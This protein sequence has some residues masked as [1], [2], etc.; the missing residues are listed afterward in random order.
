MT[1]AIFDAVFQITLVVLAWRILRARDL[2]SAVLLLCAFGLLVAL[3]WVRLN[4]PDVALAEAALGS[5]VLGALMLGAIRRLDSS[6]DL[7]EEDAA[8]VGARQR[9]KSVAAGAG[10]AGIGIML[11]VAVVD[12]AG[13]SDGLTAPALA[14]LARS[15]VSNPVTAVL[16]N[17]RGY[18]TLLEI[19]VLLAAL[20]AVWSLGVAPAATAPEANHLLRA[21]A[22]FV[23]PLAVVVAG[24][25]LWAGG[26]APGGAFQAGALLAGAAILLSWAAPR[27]VHRR[28]SLR[29][30]VFRGAA[31]LGL[32]A[33]VGAAAGTKLGTGTLLEFPPSMAKWMILLVESAATISIAAI[34]WGLC[35]M[36]EPRRQVHAADVASAPQELP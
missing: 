33:F 31:G 29:G 32:L 14:Q 15:G 30:S 34:L 12:V 20:V 21:L 28:L 7:E 4:A 1:A 3:A 9:W 13:K 11:I 18:D 24:Y 22:R 36:D 27:A 35:M 2:V 25:L 23:I 19:A 5:G 16:M 10:S 26:H 8:R 17:Y 6:P